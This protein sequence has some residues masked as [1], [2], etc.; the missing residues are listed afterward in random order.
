MLIGL[1][2]MFVIKDNGEKGQVV[3]GGK[4]KKTVIAVKAERKNI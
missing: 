3:W 4:M 2:Q 1:K